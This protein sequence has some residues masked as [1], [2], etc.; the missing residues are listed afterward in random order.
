[1][2]FGNAE[3]LG[4]YNATGEK[5]YKVLGNCTCGKSMDFIEYNLKLND[6][7]SISSKQK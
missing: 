5:V 7:G 3:Y 4:T 1:M 6:D 2:D